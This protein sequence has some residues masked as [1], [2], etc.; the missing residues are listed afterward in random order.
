MIVRYSLF[1]NYG[2]LLQANVLT[3]ARGD[4]TNRQTR[5][6]IIL[7]MCLSVNNVK[8]CMQHV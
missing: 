8:G 4:V 6:L 1:Y 3:R 2:L 7:H 5:K